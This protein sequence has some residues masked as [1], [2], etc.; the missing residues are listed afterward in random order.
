MKMH[1]YF[2]LNIKQGASQLYFGPKYNCE[3]PGDG[4]R[5]GRRG[6]VGPGG[7]ASE[8]CPGG[9]QLSS[10][11]TVHDCSLIVNCQICS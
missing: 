11:G 1:N 4:P 2:I 9:L 7:G 6:G 8:R 10:A 3:A 5:R